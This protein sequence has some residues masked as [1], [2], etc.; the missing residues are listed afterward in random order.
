VVVALLLAA[1]VGVLPSRTRASDGD[2]ATARAGNGPQGVGTGALSSA[3]LSATG[4]STYRTGRRRDDSAGGDADISAAMTLL[5]LA[6]RSGLPTWD[7][8]LAVAVGARGSVSRDLRQVAAALRWGAD[9]W[10]AWGSVG[11]GWSPAARAVTI[12]QQAGVPPGPMLLAA[13]DDLRRA[14]LDRLEVEAAKAGVRL[15]A[16]LGLV[17]LPAF[18]LTTVVPLVIA[19][20]GRLMTG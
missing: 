13:A 19:L 11:P 7:V 18:C 15:V 3:H 4:A 10:E 1:A 20:A 8:L 12:A 5:A 6:Y 2:V 17:L 14:D 16:P 9:E